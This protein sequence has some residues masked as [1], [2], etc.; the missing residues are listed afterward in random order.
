MRHCQ[1]QHLNIAAWIQVKLGWDPPGHHVDG[2]LGG[3]L[4]VLHVEV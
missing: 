1:H 2:D 3:L 4:G